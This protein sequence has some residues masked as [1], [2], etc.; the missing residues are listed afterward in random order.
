[1]RTVRHNGRTL[2]PA[3]YERGFGVSSLLIRVANWF[4]MRLELFVAERVLR[5]RK[6]EPAQTT[7][8]A[9]EAPRVAPAVRELFHTLPPGTSFA[10]AERYRRDAENPLMRV[11]ESPM[12]KRALAH[13]MR[14]TDRSVR[15]Y[16]ARGTKTLVPEDMFM[17]VIDENDIPVAP[18]PGPT[19]GDT[20]DDAIRRLREDAALRN[21]RNADF[22][23]GRSERYLS[24]PGGLPKVPRR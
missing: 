18:A 11:D 17:K 16:T 7:P 10:R 23:L 20:V 13:A 22:N 2:D 4:R 15:Y 3:P 24:V 14:H 5:L 12:L 21:L 1:V 8:S 6:P 19:S 9:P